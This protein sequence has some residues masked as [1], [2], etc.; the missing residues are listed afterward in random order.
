MNKN[1]DKILLYIYNAS[2]KINFKN[3]FDNY[4]GSYILNAVNHD[5]VLMLYPT[6]KEYRICVF[7][8]NELNFSTIKSVEMALLSLVPKLPIKILITWK[9]LDYIFHVDKLDSYLDENTLQIVKFSNSSAST[10]YVLYIK[11]ITSKGKFYFYS[12]DIVSQK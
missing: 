2:T 4:I 12:V 9:M 5:E 3:Y 8:Q 11:F 7:P 1:N 6:L 10:E